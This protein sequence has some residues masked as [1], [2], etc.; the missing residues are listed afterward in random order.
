M[1][2][3][4]IHQSTILGSWRHNSMLIRNTSLQLLIG[5][6]VSTC[7]TSTSGCNKTGKPLPGSNKLINQSGDY[8]IA[9]LNAKLIVTV[10]EDGLCS[11]SLIDQQE[12]V[13]LNSPNEFSNY[14]RWFLVWDS[15]NNAVWCHSSDI[16]TF[17]WRP[18]ETGKYKHY[19][20]ANDSEGSIT[21]M[22]DDL[23]DA[24]PD[25]FKKHWN[26]ARHP[27]TN[28]EH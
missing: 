1:S 18:D 3:I 14:H 26:K 21:I 17:V 6:L 11:Y 27:I 10:S 19:S 28:S 2:R 8:L 23:F 20:V 25:S 4:V 22:Q 16:G 13:L 5:I 9:E 7:I 15:T 24:L 12:T